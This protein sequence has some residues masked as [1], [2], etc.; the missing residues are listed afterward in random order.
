MS[1]AHRALP[2]RFWPCLFRLAILA[3]AVLAGSSGADA[4][5]ASPREY[6]IKAAFLFNFAQ[7]VEWPPATLAN[8]RASVV[9]GVLGE[10]PFDSHL[11]DTVRGET[12]GGRPLVV[13]R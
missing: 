7:F 3:A 1:T 12:V 13:V 11:E 5:S 9:V 10:D 8:P 4:E 2:R 6:Q